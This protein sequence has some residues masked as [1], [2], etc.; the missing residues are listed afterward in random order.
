MSIILI[1]L[2]GNETDQRWPEHWGA[3][4]PDTCFLWEL[5]GKD[6]MERKAVVIKRLL[7]GCSCTCLKYP[8]SRAYNRPL[9][10]KWFFF[11]IIPKPH[12]SGVCWGSNLI[13]IQHEPSST[14]PF[15]A[16]LFHNLV[17]TLEE[18]LKGSLIP[19]QKSETV[20]DPTSSYVR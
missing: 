1:N 4:L 14:H 5:A 8:K 18:F 7:L 12:H 19:N 2:S 10:L 17:D 16:K 15:P 20:I 11:G 6:V 9:S 3:R 13:K